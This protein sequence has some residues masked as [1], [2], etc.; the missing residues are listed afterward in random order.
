MTL[1]Q[2][3]LNQLLTI[4]KDLQ[5]HHRTKNVVFFEAVKTRLN[6]SLVNYY[7]SLNKSFSYL[8]SKEGKNLIKKV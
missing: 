4:K 8:S 1:Y 7:D 3:P 2:E 6:L 5:T